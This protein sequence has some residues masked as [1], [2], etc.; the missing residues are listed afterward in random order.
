M[1]VDMVLEVQDRHTRE[2]VQVTVPD[3]QN[4]WGLAIEFDRR[5][6]N[7]VI[8]V[9][10]YPTEMKF[11]CIVA[12]VEALHRTQNLAL[13]SFTS[14]SLVHKRSSSTDYKMETA[15]ILRR[16]ETG[17]C[18]CELDVVTGRVYKISKFRDPFYHTSIELYKMNEHQFFLMVR[19]NVLTKA[20]SL[21]QIWEC[22]RAR[23]R[24]VKMIEFDKSKDIVVD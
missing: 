7:E 24:L 20:V 22:T 11:I 4:F 3:M 10:G 18:V 9:L 21:Y 19:G 8:V 2:F 12:D 13:G 14:F 15:L 16:K 1:K 17:D 6:M 23:T 5:N